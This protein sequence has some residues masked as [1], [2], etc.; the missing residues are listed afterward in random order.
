MGDVPEGPVE[1]VTAGITLGDDGLSY[2]TAVLDVGGRPEIA[3]LPRVH[4]LEG[5]GDLATAAVRTDVGVDLTV[6]LTHPVRARFSIRFRL[7]EHRVVL[8]DA[9]ATGT[10]LLGTTTP[11]APGDQ[12]LWLAVDLDGS[13]LQAVIDSDDV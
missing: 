11:G 4:A 10:L 13:R 3:D 7:P 9:A 12:P 5:I 2:P 6:S 8:A 1:V